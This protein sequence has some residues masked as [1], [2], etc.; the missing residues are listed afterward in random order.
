MRETLPGGGVWG[1]QLLC[2]LPTWTLV[3][4]SIKTTAG[5]TLPVGFHAPFPQFCVMPGAQ[6]AIGRIVNECVHLPHPA[7]RLSLALMHEHTTVL[8]LLSLL[9]HLYLSG[10]H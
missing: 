4:M 6:I 7:L 5:G 1:N 8:F 10:Y 3:H 9:R 2:V